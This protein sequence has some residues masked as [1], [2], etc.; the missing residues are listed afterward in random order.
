MFW[1]RY[2]LCVCLVG[3]GYVVGATFHPR[4]TSPRLSRFDPAGE[5]RVYRPHNHPHILIRPHWVQD[6]RGPR[7]L[8]GP[9]DPVG[10]DLW[11]VSLDGGRVRMIGTALDGP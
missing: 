9:V 7:L 11:H 3:V 6:E 8:H 10:R 5:V 1:K 4:S 2:L